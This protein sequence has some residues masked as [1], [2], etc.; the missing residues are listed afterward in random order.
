M[1]QIVLALLLGTL[2]LAQAA[3]LATQAAAQVDQRLSQGL[4]D[5]VK[6]LEQ[7][8]ELT[9]HSLE[10]TLKNDQQVKAPK[11]KQQFQNIVQLP[12]QT[13]GPIMLA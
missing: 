12:I 8:D 10:A 7:L 5:T 11:P 4:M 2:S 9:T 1:K 13:D 6:E 3:K